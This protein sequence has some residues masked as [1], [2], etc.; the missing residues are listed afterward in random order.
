MRFL[1]QSIVPV[2]ATAS[3]LWSAAATA[4]TFDFN[5]PKG[6]NS[7]TVTVDSQLE[8]IRGTAAQVGGTVNFDPAKPEALT[9]KLTV[10]A[11]AVKLTNDR[12]T[13]VLHSED[14]INAAAH[15]TITFTFTKVLSATRTNDTRHNIRTQGNMTLN[16][17]TRDIEVDLSL[18]HLPGK[19]RDRG[20]K[21]DGDLL[22]LRCDFSIDRTEF[23]IK[24]D[25]DGTVVG[26]EIEIG[27]GIVGI[28]PTS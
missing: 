26:Q 19:L 9:G 23:N 10:P 22:I 4:A 20:G 6:V 2:I 15:P 16:G 21:V 3:V 13:E 12:M 7:M 17:V 1:T 27:V 8:P 5:D 28:S 24:S 14:W 18:S 11:A 25:M